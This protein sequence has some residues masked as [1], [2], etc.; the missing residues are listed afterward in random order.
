MDKQYDKERDAFI[1]KM[2]GCSK[3]HGKE[4]DLYNKTYAEKILRVNTLL[5]EAEKSEDDMQKKSYYY[6]QAL[7]VFYYLIPDNETED[8][9]VKQL[10]LKAHRGQA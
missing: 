7:L 4:I 3:D 9:E 6:A 5:T 10:E 1:Q 2:I 8:A